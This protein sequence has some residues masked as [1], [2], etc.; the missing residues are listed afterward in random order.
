MTKAQID[1]ALA[2]AQVVLA[3]I[4]ELGERLEA[5]AVDDAVRDELATD[6]WAGAAKLASFAGAVAA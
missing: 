6:L 4:T 1:A 3:A 2:E 5:N